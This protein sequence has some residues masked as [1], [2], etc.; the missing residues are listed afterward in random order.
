MGGCLQP[1]E[2]HQ[3]WQA[4]DKTRSRRRLLPRKIAKRSGKRLAVAVLPDVVY[5]SGKRPPYRGGIFAA[6]TRRFRADH[7]HLRFRRHTADGHRHRLC[8][9]IVAAFS[10][11]AADALDH[12]ARIFG[13]VFSSFLSAAT[14]LAQ[15]FPAFRIST[16]FDLMQ[17]FST[18]Q[19]W[20]LCQCPRL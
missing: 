14:I 8:Q 17:L 20:R 7:L 16:R 15:F 1:S 10:P 2:L 11:M 5:C 18:K 3:S 19:S 4:N 6:K 9:N 13:H 12:P